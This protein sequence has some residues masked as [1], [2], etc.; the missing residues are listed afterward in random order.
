MV[1]RQVNIYLKEKN[2]A[3]VRKM[4]GPRRISHYI[5]EAL[6]EKLAKD[7]AREQAQLQEKLTAGYKRVAQKRKSQ[8][9]LEIFDEAVDDYINK[10]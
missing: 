3:A 5:D 9:A 6:E 8:K 10:K 1:G 2:Y 7:Q 4:V